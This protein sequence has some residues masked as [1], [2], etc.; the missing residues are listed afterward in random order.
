MLARM[1]TAP[2]VSPDLADLT[3]PR[4]VQHLLSQKGLWLSKTRGQHLLVDQDV[5]NRIV[6]AA[7]LT[8]DQSVL[9]VGPG[10]GVLTRALARVAAEVVAVE[11]D[12][13][14]VEL[15]EETVTAPNVQ[16]VQADALH[17]ALGTL[18][19]GKPYKVVANLPYGIATALIR[20]LLSAET[21]R[22]DEMV[23]M[24]QRE[25]A[26]RLAAKP[27]DMSLLAVEVQMLADVKLLFDVGRRSFFPEPDVESAVVRITPLLA[28]RV[29]FRPERQRF[30]QTVAAGFS[31]KR[32]QL[33]NS[34]GPLGVGTEHIQEALS[35]TGIDPIRRAETLTLEE[36]SRLSEALWRK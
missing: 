2:R 19:G 13:R 18:M 15:L 23:V 14:M 17:V 20:T 1:K 34:L 6:T 8:P 32:K 5:L 7:R 10:A 16:V 25:V 26:Q 28:P 30:F 33:H 24:V 29:P 9:E 3:N 11:V 36:W 31:Q 4:H 12:R 21:G 35:E 22:P 27:G